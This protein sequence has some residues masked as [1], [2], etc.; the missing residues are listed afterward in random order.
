MYI[1]YQRF[2]FQSKQEW[3]EQIYIKLQRKQEWLEHFEYF[4]VTF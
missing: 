4:S 3:Q 1:Q 2:E